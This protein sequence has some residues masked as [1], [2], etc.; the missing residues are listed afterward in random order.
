MRF[1]PSF[2]PIAQGE[3]GKVSKNKGLNIYCGGEGGI[4]THGGV[5]PTPHFECGTFNHS[6][7]SPHLLHHKRFKKR[8]DSSEHQKQVPSVQR[9]NNGQNTIRQAVIDFEQEK[10]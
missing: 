3:A 1:V 10:S 7:T 8:T 6:A 9:F 5:A 2:V 4:R